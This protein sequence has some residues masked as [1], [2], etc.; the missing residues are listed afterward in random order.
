MEGEGV[1]LSS[2]E[3][4]IEAAIPADEFERELQH[5]DVATTTASEHE[6][7]SSTA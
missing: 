4:A 3:A 6:S 7:T 5:L 2:G 1:V